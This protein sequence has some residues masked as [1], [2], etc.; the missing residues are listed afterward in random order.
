MRQQNVVVLQTMHSTYFGVSDG[1]LSDQVGVEDREPRFYF[2][3][4]E[5]ES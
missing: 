5:T 1:V 3:S 4:I 2:S